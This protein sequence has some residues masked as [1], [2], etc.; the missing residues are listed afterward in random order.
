MHEKPQITFVLGQYA[1]KLML[2]INISRFNDQRVNS[3][4]ITL[5][6][7]VIVKDM[8]WTIMKIIEI[9]IKCLMITN[10]CM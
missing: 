2:I 4:T 9:R 7:S 3:V 6:A 8:V 10:L 5:N 1:A